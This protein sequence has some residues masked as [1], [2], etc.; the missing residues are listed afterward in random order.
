MKIIRTKAAGV[1][2]A[3]VVSREGS[4]LV[5]KNAIRL[6]RWEGAASLSQLAVEGV[7]NPE[8]CKFCVPI[9]VIVFEVIEIIDTTPAAV[10]SI[11]SVTPWKM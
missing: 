4:T 6:W 2:L 7:K 1:F 8:G 3:E 5:L 10:S 11:L 9:S